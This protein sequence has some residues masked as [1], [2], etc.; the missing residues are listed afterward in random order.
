MKALQE[1]TDWEYKN[2]IYITTDSKEK[3]IAYVVDG[4]LFTFP[5]PLKFDTRRRKFKE[6]KNTWITE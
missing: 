1:T 2:H 3:L 4:E 5:K 6:V